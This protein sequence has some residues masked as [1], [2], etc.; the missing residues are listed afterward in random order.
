MTPQDI[1]RYIE[2][3][4]LDAFEARFTTEAYVEQAFADLSIAEG[5]AL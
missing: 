2:R 1:T 4:H 5:G 3:A